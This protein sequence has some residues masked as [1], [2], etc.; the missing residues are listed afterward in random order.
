MKKILIT[1]LL[2]LA[3]SLF[4]ESISEEEIFTFRYSLKN[5][6]FEEASDLLNKFKNAKI[7]QAKYELLETEFW[8]AKGEDLYQQKKYKSS[9][10]YFNNAYSRWR[11]NPLIKERYTELAGKVLHDEEQ[12]QPLPPI[13]PIKK[14]AEKEKEIV[15][16][17][18]NS[19]SY[20]VINSF[21]ISEL[22]EQAKIIYA[23]LGSIA[24]LFLIQVIINLILLIR[25]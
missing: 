13:K 4:A 15:F 10:E 18:T 7:D 12:L 6:N 9:F 19:D 23:L 16:I 20:F 17:D 11:T 8:I 1:T 21:R 24:L 5:K 14:L 25:K 2:L 3:I 22:E